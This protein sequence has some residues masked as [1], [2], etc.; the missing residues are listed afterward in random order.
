MIVFTC[1]Y[2]N[3]SIPS[4]PIIF[5]KA[6]DKPADILLTIFFLVESISAASR[7]GEIKKIIKKMN[8]RSINGIFNKPTKKSQ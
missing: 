1:N 5:S 6:D 2:L 3:L 7:W 8:E 4:P